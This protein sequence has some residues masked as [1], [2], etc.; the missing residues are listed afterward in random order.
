V[1]WLSVYSGIGAHDLGFQRAG[2]TIV[3]Q[4]EIEP[5]CRAV[6]EKHWR[7]LP[8]WADVRDVTAGIIRATCGDIDGITGGFACQ[9][10]S[11][12]GR[13]AGLGKATRSGLTWRN[14]FRLIRGL[15][16]GWVVIENVPRLKTLGYDRV[17]R[18]LERIGY[19]VR[20]IV[21]GALH[22]GARIRR[23]RTWIVGNAIGIGQPSTFHPGKCFE[24]IAKKAAHAIVGPM[25]HAWPVGPE[26]VPLIPR[27]VDGSAGRMDRLTAIGNANPPQVAE[28]IARAVM[29]V[30]DLLKSETTK[31]AA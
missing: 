14:L 2:C 26:F 27:A 18:V 17:A 16:P 5:F 7:G 29:A 3:G 19:S 12:A 4:I 8:R 23:H 20:P 9:D 15:R 13:G 24:A 25:R 28:A 11:C 10:V 21:V 30:N 1:K 31:G 22:A 6:L